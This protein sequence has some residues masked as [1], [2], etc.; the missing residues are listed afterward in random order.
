M[1]PCARAQHEAPHT[2]GEIA[3]NI[4]L[5]Q[6]K[7]DLALF[8]EGRGEG[9]V[10]QRQTLADADISERLRKLTAGQRPPTVRRM[11]ERH[12][13]TALDQLAVKSDPEIN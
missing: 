11:I 4:C 5:K 3:L 2:R 8:V 7:V 12:S 13:M 9:Q 6:R 10:N 1:H